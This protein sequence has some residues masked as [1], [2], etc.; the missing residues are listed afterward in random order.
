L[1]RDK[2]FFINHNDP[3]VQLQELIRGLRL[4]PEPNRFFT[5][6]AVCN[7][8][9]EP[10]EGT[11]AYGRVPDYIWTAHNRFSQCKRCRKL[12]WEGSHLERNR[13]EIARLLGEKG[14]R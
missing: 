3:R 10:I 1:A 12:Y 14:G 13:K 11:D 4:R 2:L 8:V 5:R 7:E 9:L 6:C